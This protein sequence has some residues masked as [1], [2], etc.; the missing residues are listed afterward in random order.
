VCVCVCVCVCHALASVPSCHQITLCGVVLVCL[1]LF[2]VK[3]HI[4]AFKH[5][6]F[7]NTTA[8]LLIWFGHGTGN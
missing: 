3:M 6:S 4:S 7:Y 5:R 2:H 8:G 1:S